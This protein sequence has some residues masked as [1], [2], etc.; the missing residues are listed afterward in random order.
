[1]HESYVKENCL[2]KDGD[3]IEKAHILPYCETADNHFENL[4][5]LCPNCHKDFDKI[6]CF[7][8]DEVKEW[9]KLEKM[10][11]NRFFKEFRL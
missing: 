7:I 3:I 11:V 5:I 9:E 8:A 10:R 2:E 1:M 6:L 4:I